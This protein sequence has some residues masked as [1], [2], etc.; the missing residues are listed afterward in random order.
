MAL[1]QLIKKLTPAS[2]SFRTPTRCAIMPR[3]GRALRPGADRRHRSPSQDGPVF[4]RQLFQG[5]LNADYRHTATGPASSRCRRARS[6]PS[7]WRRAAPASKPS[8]RRSMPAQIRTKPARPS[9]NQ[10]RRWT[11]SSRRIIVSV[12]RGIKEQDNLPARSRSWLRRSA[13]SLRH[14]GPSA[15][16]AGCP[17]SGRSAAPARRSRPSS[18]SP[19]ASL[20]RS[21]TWL[22]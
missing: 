4:M 1:Q 15:T 11:W 14:R 22:A 7:R 6:A 2:S 20:A 16:T 18:I 9:A 13:P 5:K 19:S 3:A 17:W 10:R 8:L 21:S 12:G